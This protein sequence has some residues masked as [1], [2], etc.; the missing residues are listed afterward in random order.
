[1]EQ[2]SNAQ[3][4]EGICAFLCVLNMVVMYNTE[5]SSHKLNLWI[6]YNNYMTNKI[7]ISLLR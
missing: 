5:Y 3:Q 6:K 4:R 2:E 7:F 1:M